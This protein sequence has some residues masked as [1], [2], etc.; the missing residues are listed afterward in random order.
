MCGRYLF[1]DSRNPKILELI[2]AAEK[3]LSPEQ[4]SSISLFEVFPSQNIFSGIYDPAEKKYKTVVMKWGLAGVQNRSIINC[5][6]ETFSVSLYF[7]GCR[8]CA[9]PACGYYEWSKN[10]SCKYYFT[11]EKQPL[12]LAGCWRIEKTDDQTL[13]M[14][15]AILTEPSASIASSIHSRQPIVFDTENAHLW[16]S[17][18]NPESM[19]SLS[20][21]ERIMTKA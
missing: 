11:I 10:P 21:R 8:T 3:S 20:I 12:Y 2:K 1:Y 4:F 5:R 17:T 19:Y 13:Q 16:C 7:K 15:C 9:I 6:S 18:D 14:A